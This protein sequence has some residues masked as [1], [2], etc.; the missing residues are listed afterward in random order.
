MTTTTPHADDAHTQ[1]AVALRAAALIHAHAPDGTPRGLAPTTLEI[2]RH[3]WT[4]LVGPNG[5]GKSTLAALA[6]ALASP[7]QGEV[8]I[9]GHT[10][11]PDSAPPRAVRTELA[12][13]TQTT[14]ADPLLTVRENLALTATLR[15][16]R[17]NDAK[18]AVTASAAAFE[19]TDR[20]DDRVKTLSGGLARRTDLARALVAPRP[21]CVLDEPDAGLDAAARS[22]LLNRIRE[23]TAADA[24]V[25]SI[26]HDAELARHAD[27]VL[28]LDAAEVIADAT[29]RDLLKPLGQLVVR[30]APTESAE[31]VERLAATHGATL[32]ADERGWIAVGQRAESLAVAC[33]HAG[34]SATL[35]PPTIDDSVR[36]AAWAV[37]ARHA[38]VRTAGAPTDGGTQ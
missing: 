32:H 20:L 7:T 4:A 35:S 28:V 10:L 24:A 9:L 8:T 11:G 1:P 22:L 30:I 12:L 38:P 29:P 23:L 2:R 14:T 17:G 16:L 36:T 34:I 37:R 3:Q 18:T 26:T 33:A 5:S 13:V 31:A 21:L 25:L 27:R 6:A 15:G 19:L